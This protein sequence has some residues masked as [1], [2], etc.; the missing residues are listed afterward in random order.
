M[1]R[2][3]FPL[4][5]HTVR[6]GHK[7]RDMHLILHWLGDQDCDGMISPAGVTAVFVV[8]LYRSVEFYKNL[9]VQKR[10]KSYFTGNRQQG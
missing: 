5:D 10:P 7:Q 2:P 6:R 4:L 9:S 8:A 3:P 1:T